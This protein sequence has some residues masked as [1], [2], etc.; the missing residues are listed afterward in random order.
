M[1]N[2][3]PRYIQYVRNLL[4]GAM[5][6]PCSSAYQA[7]HAIV[8]ARRNHEA[9][10][11]M[12]AD[13]HRAFFAWNENRARHLPS[14]MRPESSFWETVLTELRM[15]EEQQQR[16][17]DMRQGVISWL[18]D[19]EKHPG[20][21][22]LRAALELERRACGHYWWVFVQDILTPL[23]EAWLDAGPLVYPWTA[24][25][26]A[27]GEAIAKKNGADPAPNFDVLLNTPQ[28]LVEAMPSISGFQV[29]TAPCTAYG[30]GTQLKRGLFCC[31]FLCTGRPDI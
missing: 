17:L 11:S 29:L 28:D 24:D 22:M 2:F 25:T 9:G 4:P 20:I 10:R 19:R 3:F 12:Y 23:Q 1:Q 6:D 13:L 30:A 16:V 21:Q 14:N 31:W 5:A 27:L 26:W 15:T 7:L 18:E 8:S